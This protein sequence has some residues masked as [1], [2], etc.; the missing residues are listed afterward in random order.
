MPVSPAHPPGHFYSPVNDPEA[1]DAWDLNERRQT[2]GLDGI[3]GVELDLDRF[4]QLWRSFEPHFRSFDFPQHQR[5]DRRYF[6][7]N[8]VYGL[9]DA[10]ILYSMIGVFKPST[11]VEIGS[12][13]SS[14][15][16]LDTVD[17][18]SL[19][20]QMTFIEPFPDRLERLLTPE[21]WRRCR[22]LRAP[23]QRA[24]LDCYASL[25]QNDI[26]FVDSTHVMKAQS[27]VNFE[28]FEILPR[29]AAGAIVRFHDVFW[30]FEY[31]ADWLINRRY[32]WNELYGLR[33]FLSFNSHF[34]V[35]FFNDLF[36]VHRSSLFDAAA[37]DP[38]IKPFLKTAGGGLWLRKIR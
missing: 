2:T 25:G 18:F 14:A 37:L 26:L 34:E 17:R 1:L 16:I 15:C 20:C 5:P 38:A 8:P 31:P 19:D 22:I 32:S 11:I 12:G 13:F 24:P 33:A 6:F 7:S 21:D 9:G 36:F 27:D 35:M 29:L 10:L 30:P 4:E 28:L 3:A 23:V